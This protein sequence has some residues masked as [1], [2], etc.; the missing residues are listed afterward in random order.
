MSVAL[1]RVDG[2]RH[3][4]RVLFPCYGAR[5]GVLSSHWAP[6]REGPDGHGTAKSVRA[7]FACSCGLGEDRQPGMKAIEPVPHG[8]PLGERDCSCDILEADQ[9]GGG[10]ADDA[11]DLITWQQALLGEC[12]TTA[13]D[14]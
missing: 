6:V 11:I 8:G 3:T 13:F 9:V 12:G 2:T 5:A 14:D 4:W 7:F 1:G 10:I